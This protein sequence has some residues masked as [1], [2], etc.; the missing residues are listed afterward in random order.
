MQ[1]PFV[2]RSLPADF[3][4]VRLDFLPLDA[5]DPRLTKD[6]REEL[7]PDILAVGI[8]NRHDDVPPDHELVPTT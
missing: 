4:E 1:A 6:P 5:G 2:A 3:L 8:G 7:E